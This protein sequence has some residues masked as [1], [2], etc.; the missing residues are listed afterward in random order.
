MNAADERLLFD[1]ALSGS[2]L[3]RARERLSSD[4]SPRTR[5]WFARNKV[6]R[7]I[8]LI[9]A[10]GLGGHSC[11]IHRAI[12]LGA[13]LDLSIAEAS[14]IV[15]DSAAGFGDRDIAASEIS[16]QIVEGL[17]ALADPDLP[18]SVQERNRIR[19]R[20]LAKEIAKER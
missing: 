20:N 2:Q 16:F 8:A 12:G 14:E 13:E 11:G 7:N 6:Q 17:S 5:P 18:I 4:P 9:V 1:S 19:L 10:L 15:E 3:R